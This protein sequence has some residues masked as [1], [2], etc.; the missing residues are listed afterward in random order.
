[1]FLG[2]DDEPPDLDERTSFWM[3]CFNILSRTRPPAMGGIPPINPSTTL[4]LADRLQWPCEADECL[5]VI[6]AMDD[7][8]REMNQQPSKK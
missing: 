7:Q 5:T 4:D 3:R 2:V 1:M 8:F 6:M